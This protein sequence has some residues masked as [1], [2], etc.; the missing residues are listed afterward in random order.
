M[1]GKCRINHNAKIVASTSLAI[2]SKAVNINLETQTQ[3]VVEC[4]HMNDKVIR[5]PDYDEDSVARTIDLMA[6]GAFWVG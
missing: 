3:M 6:S 1:I 2:S 5:S 4:V